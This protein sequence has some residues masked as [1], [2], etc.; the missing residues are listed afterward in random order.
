[1]SSR[2]VASGHALPANPVYLDFGKTDGDAKQLPTN[3]REVVDTDGQVNYMKPLGLE[4]SSNIHWRYQI[5]MKIAERM[6]KPCMYSLLRPFRELPHRTILIAS[7]AG[8]N[9]VLRSWPEGYH[10]Y[11]HMKGKQS[12]PRQDIYLMGMPALFR[13]APS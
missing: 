6:G 3:T 10:L 8:K 11:C 9:Y 4:D 5:A 1:M 13:D 12:A 2:S 7:L